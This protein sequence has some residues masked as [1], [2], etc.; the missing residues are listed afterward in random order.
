LGVIEGPGL[1]NFD[2]S[3]YKR[4]AVTENK[5]LEFRAEFFNAFNRPNFGNPGT[6]FGTG[7]FG[8]ISSSLEGR[9]IQLGIR[10]D[11]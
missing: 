5:H 10:F 6:T 8:V 1:V 3:L 4:F 11:F 7:S 9:D 2:L